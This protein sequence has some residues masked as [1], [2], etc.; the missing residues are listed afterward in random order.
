MKLL[1]KAEKNWTKIT[2]IYLNLLLMIPR[3]RMIDKSLRKSAKRQGKIKKKKLNRL[4]KTFKQSWVIL[5][6]TKMLY[7]V[8][9]KAK[10]S[11]FRLQ[12][13]M[14]M[15]GTIAGKALGQKKRR[16]LS[17]NGLCLQWIVIK[18]KKSFLTTTRLYTALKSLIC[19]KYGVK[20]TQIM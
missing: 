13:T 11:S 19:S 12:R 8:F 17:T 7:W 9:T 16:Q 18:M 3:Q 10:P 4:I 2:E 5:R 15:S 1:R 6:K 14:K 20:S